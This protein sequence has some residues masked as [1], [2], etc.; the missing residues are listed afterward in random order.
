MLKESELDA[1][2][3]CFLEDLLKDQRNKIIVKI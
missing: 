2:L 1:Q 3:A